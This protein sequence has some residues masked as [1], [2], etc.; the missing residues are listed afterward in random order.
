MK[1][2]NSADKQQKTGKTGKTVRAIEEFGEQQLF[3]LA[4]GN[5]GQG[6]LT[7]GLDLGDRANLQGR[8]S[9]RR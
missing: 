3:A 9:A 7:I 4:A 8:A 6:R 5:G 1:K 2:N